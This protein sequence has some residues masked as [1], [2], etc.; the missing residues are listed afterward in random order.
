MIGQL[1]TDFSASQYD[2]VNLSTKAFT[3]WPL[4]CCKSHYP[5]II[6]ERI[7]FFAHFLLQVV[8]RTDYVG[9]LAASCGTEVSRFIS[10]FFDSDT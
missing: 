4:L 6:G 5:G 7:I 2:H 8:R 3:Q 1:I 10:G 9:D